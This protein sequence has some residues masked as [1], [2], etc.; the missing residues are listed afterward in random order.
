MQ[1]VFPEVSKSNQLGRLDQESFSGWDEGANELT[2]ELDPYPVNQSDE[3]MD[4]YVGGPA[5]L[6]SAAIQVR[7]STYEEL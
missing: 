1:K 7:R 6:F 3:A 5:A 4:V 2:V